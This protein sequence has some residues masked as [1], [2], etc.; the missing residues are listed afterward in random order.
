MKNLSHLWFFLQ[1]ICFD[2]LK[3]PIGRKKIK[4]PVR[5]KITDAPY[6]VKIPV[7]LKISV[8][9]KNLCTS[10]GKPSGVVQVFRS[11]AKDCRQNRRG[12]RNTRPT[13]DHRRRAG[14]RQTKKFFVLYIGIIEPNEKYLQKMLKKICRYQNLLYLCNQKQQTTPRKGKR[15]YN[16]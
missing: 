8:G 1:K 14:E 12:C 13:H 10:V 7:R 9:S 4:I 2:Y 5:L 11:P 15:K 6:F 3:I 16:N